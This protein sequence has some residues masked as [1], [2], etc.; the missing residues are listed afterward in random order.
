[1]GIVDTPRFENGS[2]RLKGLASCRTPRCQTARA[3][4]DGDLPLVSCIMPTANR[5]RFVPEAIRLFLP[6]D[7]SEGVGRP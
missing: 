4:R 3:T 2:C 1:M 6:Q 7:Y 5:R